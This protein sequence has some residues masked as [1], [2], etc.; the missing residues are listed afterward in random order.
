MLKGNIYYF[1][2]L[3]SRLFRFIT[4]LYL[5]FFEAWLIKSKHL[6]HNQ[7]L[8]MKNNLCA[9]NTKSKEQSVLTFRFNWWNFASNELKNIYIFFCTLRLLFI[10]WV[11]L[12]TKENW[13]WS[14]LSALEDVSEPKESFRI[15]SFMPPLKK[16]KTM[17]TCIKL[18]TTY[19]HAFT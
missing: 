10:V 19:F 11:A 1:S 18:F 2:F 14:F 3:S 15:F 5:L 8:N 13:F 12:S 17:Q 9:W 7:W 6:K 4:L 16:M